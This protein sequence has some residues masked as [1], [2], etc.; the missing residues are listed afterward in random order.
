MR[1]FYVG[2]PLAGALSAGLSGS[3]VHGNHALPYVCDKSD[4]EFECKT[5]L[6]VFARHLNYKLFIF[7]IQTLR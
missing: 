7:Q 3:G 1:P 6:V 5:L 2:A 4:V